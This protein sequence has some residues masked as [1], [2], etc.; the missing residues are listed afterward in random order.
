MP[1][2]LDDPKNLWNFCPNLGADVFFCVLFG[3]FSIIHTVQAIRYRKWYCTVVIIASYWQTATYIARA[4]SI[5]HPRNTILYTMWSI[6]ILIGPLWIN[7]FVYMVVGRMVF[8]F[9]DNH[10]LGGVKAWKLGTLF[11]CFD[12]L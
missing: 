1:L 3:V 6:L 11:V 10:K 9:L 4:L 5:I 7:A 12:I 2:A 8:N